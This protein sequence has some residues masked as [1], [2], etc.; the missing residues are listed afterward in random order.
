[1]PSCPLSLRI[2]PGELQLSRYGDGLRRLNLILLVALATR[3]LKR[4]IYLGHRGRDKTK[5][6]TQSSANRQPQQHAVN[7]THH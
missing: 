5:R 2:S 7:R 3:S 4:L 6:N 1:M